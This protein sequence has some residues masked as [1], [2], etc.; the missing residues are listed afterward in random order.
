MP[1][2]QN[3]GGTIKNITKLTQNVGGTLKTLTSLKQNV[4]GTLKEVFSYSTWDPNKLYCFQVQTIL[5]GGGI[6]HP[7]SSAG[8]TRHTAEKGETITLSLASQSVSTGYMVSN[9]KSVNTV[10][11]GVSRSYFCPKENCT[12]VVSITYEGSNTYNGSCSAYI[13]ID[14]VNKTAG[15][16]SVTTSTQIGISMQQGCSIAPSGAGVSSASC[17]GVTMTIDFI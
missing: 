11:G 9:S 14:G 4:G 6:G 10:D 16:Y 12:M 2:Y 15:S 7:S 1:L 5:V 3:V 13:V 17:Q 8:F